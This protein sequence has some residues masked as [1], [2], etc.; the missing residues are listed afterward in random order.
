MFADA[1]LKC[2][3][4]YVISQLTV[5]SYSRSHERTLCHVTKLTV[6]FYCRCVHTCWHWWTLD[7]EDV[8]IQWHY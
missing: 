6:L 4:L 8:D 3:W 5:L 2:N 1:V 7:Q